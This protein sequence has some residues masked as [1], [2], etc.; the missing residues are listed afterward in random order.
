MLL[1]Q[2]K[3]IFWILILLAALSTAA[4]PCDSAFGLGSQPKP[5]YRHDPGTPS[6]PEQN[7][8]YDWDDASSTEEIA[9]IQHATDTLKAY[10]HKSDCFKEAARTLRQ[11]CKSIDIDL[12]EKTKYAIR[13]TACE[14]ATANM[15][16]PLECRD[17]ISL[18]ESSD[19]NDNE[20]A[21]SGIGR[22]LE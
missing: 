16:V 6:K 14:V 17:I 21:N 1:C 11:N 3:D 2:R 8:P 20:I 18:N 7:Y 13:L 15:A 4:T 22:C 5:R 19:R 10:D 9:I 12:D